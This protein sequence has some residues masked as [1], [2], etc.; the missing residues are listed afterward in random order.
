VRMS[1]GPGAN[2]PEGNLNIKLLLAPSP[3]KIIIIII[4]IIIKWLLGKWELC[5]FSV[6]TL[7]F[8]VGIFLESG[9]SLGQRRAAI[10]TQCF[11]LSACFYFQG[12]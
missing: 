6:R 7:C 3:R 10:L 9:F 4:I 8:E 5:E 12:R 2:I 11:C 1:L